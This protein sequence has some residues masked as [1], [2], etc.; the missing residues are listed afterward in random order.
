MLH[1]HRCTRVRELLRGI[2]GQ[3]SVHMSSSVASE[4]GF[5]NGFMM[6]MFGGGGLEELGWDGWEGCAVL[7]YLVWCCVSRLV[8]VRVQGLFSVGGAHQTPSTPYHRTIHH[9]PFS[10][11]LPSL[12]SCHLFPTDIPTFKYV[13]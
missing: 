4:G 2:A 3:S 6:M 5:V 9:S 7:L 1:K 10:F 12:T 13:Q 11:P 8:P